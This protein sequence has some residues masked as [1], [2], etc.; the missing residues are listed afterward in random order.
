MRAFL[1]VVA[2]L[3]AASLAGC[4]E[5]SEGTPQDGGTGTHDAGPADSGAP[6]FELLVLDESAPGE[7][8]IA[9]AVAGDRVGVA[10]FADTGGSP[11]RQLRYVEPGSAPEAVADVDNVFGVS[12]AFDA[13]G[14]PLIAHLGGGSDESL[15]WKQSD[16]A[17]S[18]RGASGWATEVLARESGEVQTGIE[19]SDIGKVVGVNPA[20]L[21]DEAGEI[22]V[23][24]RDIHGGQFPTDYQHSDIEVVEGRPGAWRRSMA[25]VGGDSEYGHGGVMSGALADGLPALAWSAQPGS[26]MDN[27]QD[28][29]FARRDASGEWTEPKLLKVTGG[30]R[31][32]PVL[33]WSSVTGYGIAV[34][35]RSK[36]ILSY[37]ES[38]NGTSW[39]PAEP[40]VG[41]GTGGWYP[42]LAFA[43]EGEPVIA[44]YVCSNAS[45]A[46]VCNP[47]ED[48]LVLKRRR[49]GVWPAREEVVDP[50]GASWPR[51][52]LAGSKAVVAYKD[53]ERT[54]LKVAVEK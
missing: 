13:E 48:A 6:Q 33:A 3:M 32:G 14:A 8:P 4:S 52:A 38:A 43:P 54:V 35:D 41:A 39:L 29:W 27:P 46:T 2:G 28:V 25:V 36:G 24:H 44:Y 18:R 7:Y 40:I 26:A 50:E 10:Y 19:T 16:L 53:P 17:L 51:L 12:L 49:G 21:V 5:G 45:A 9:V 42:S 1:A 31:A 22:F 23:A 15:Y 20:L 34:E 11:A 47:S 37:L 30:T